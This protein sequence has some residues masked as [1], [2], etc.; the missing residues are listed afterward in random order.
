MATDRILGATARLTAA[1]EGVQEAPPDEHA[2]IQALRTLLLGGVPL[3]EPT[4]PQNSTPRPINKEPVFIWSPE[5][6][7]NPTRSVSINSPTSVPSR[8][9]TSAI[10]KDDADNESLPPTLLR[11]SPWS[12]ATLSTTT[13]PARLNVRSSDMMNCVIATHVLTEVQLPSPTKRA[14]TCQQGY[15][16]EA[17]LIHNNEL[18]ST[19]NA[20]EHFIGAVIDDTTG[21]VLEY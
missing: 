20:S 7:Q 11:R 1:I 18:Q 15:A 2:A 10:I 3:T 12:N 8:T 16:F 13:G 4:S 17:H 21:G 14:P 5:E 9:G 6:V 19:A